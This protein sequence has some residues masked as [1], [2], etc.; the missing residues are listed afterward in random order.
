MQAVVTAYA[1][2]ELV[3]QSKLIDNE[4]DMELASTA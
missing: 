4:G 1:Q 3:K 2:W